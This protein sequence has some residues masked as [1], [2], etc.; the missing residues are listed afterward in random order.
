LFH[1]WAEIRLRVRAAQRLAIFLDFDGTLVGLR[2][3]PGDVRVPG[4]VKEILARLARHENVS[5]A[6]VSGRRLRDL[7][8]MIGVEG[9]R[10]FGLHGAEQDGR[11]VALSKGARLALGRAKREAR[12][13]LGVLPGIWLEDKVCSLAIHYRGA[14]P[15][16]VREAN[17]T[18]LGI[19]APLRHGLFVISGE[20]VWEILPRTF[21]GKGATVLALLAR[22]P[23]GTLAIYAGDDTSDETAF[24][25]LAEQITVGVGRRRGSRARFGVRNPADVLR[26]LTRVEKELS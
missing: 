10:Y 17:G 13:Q 19:L 21:V 22:M 9:V 3:R 8:S 6:I 26:F 2:R 7:H 12:V 25:A 5:I 23:R 24:A 15:A 4:L 14:S 20:K 11:K 1:A 18:L 16:F